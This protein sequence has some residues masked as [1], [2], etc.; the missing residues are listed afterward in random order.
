MKISNFTSYLFLIFTLLLQAPNLFATEEDE[1]PSMAKIHG[2]VKANGEPLPHASVQIKSTMLGTATNNEGEFEMRVPEGSQTIV[3]RALGYKPKE[4]NVD[5]KC[6][7]RHQNRRGFGHSQ[8]HASGEKE[9]SAKMVNHFDIN[10]EEDILGLEQV[11]V[12]ADRNSEKR[13]ESSVIVN[14]LD[15]AMLEAIQSANLS[16]GLAFSPGLRIENN[17]GNCGANS[18][19]MNGMDGPYTQ[20]L[21][22]GRPIFSGL[23]AVYGLELIPSNMIKRV[24]VVRGGGSALYG[25]NA[26]AG[27]VNVLTR[28]PT[29]NQYSLSTQTGHVGSFYDQA[30]PGNEHQVNFNA[31]L[32]DEERKNGLALY[33]S[34]RN[35]TPFDANDDG[36]SELSEIDNTTIGAQWSLRTGYKSKLVTDFFH[37]EEHRR[38][39]DNFDQP[40]HEALIAEATEHNINTGNISWHLFTDANQELTTFVAAQKINRDSYYGAGKALDAYGNTEDLSYSGGAQYKFVFD[41]GNVILGAEMN[42]GNLHDKK[43]GYRE[44]VIDEEAMDVVEEEV[45]SRTIADQETMV[46]GG[47]AQMER[48]LGQFSLSGGLRLDHYNITDNANGSELS[49]NV[50]SPRVTMLYGVYSP[51]QVRMSYAQGY[52]APQIFDEDLHIETSDSRQVIHKND[53]NLKQETSHSYTG[54]LSYII[55]NGG[56]NLELLSEFF[57][58]NLNNPFANEIGSPDAQGRVIY[59]RVNESEG[60]T[61]KGIN[62]EAK[63]ATSKTMSFN[64]GF[65]FQNSKYGAPQDFDETRFLRTPDTYGYFTFNW[66]PDSPWEFSSNGTYTGKM[67]VPYFGPLAANLEEGVLNE[68]DPFFDWSVKLTYNFDTNIGDFDIF[69]GAKNILNSYQSDFDTGKDRDPGYIYGPVNPRTIYAGLRI[70]NIF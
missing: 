32:T 19:R 43:L 35:R 62:L 50:L 5:I 18:L 28:E 30:N 66:T 15:N 2:A 3:V 36:F 25:S 52:R 29:N 63:W 67:L 24:E 46:G 59:T 38:G 11:V 41:K 64:S 26:I 34:V 61:V 23:A 4:L 6:H 60:A 7:H 14:S 58:T 20:I 70:S 22:N 65:T 17:C 9:S 49:N 12:T 51:F 68:S 56:S 31:T 42:G 33:G 27:T 54:S 39:G 1:Q 16:E 10:M 53:P 55:E 48:Q 37:I 8:R 13:K 69:A 47:F 44:F 45:P 40:L 57:L 21:I